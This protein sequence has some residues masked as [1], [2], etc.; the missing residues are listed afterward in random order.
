MFCCRMSSATWS[1]SGTYR[2]VRPWSGPSPNCCTLRWRRSS[3]PNYCPRPRTALLRSDKHSLYVYQDIS[4]RDRQIMK[5]V[6]LTVVL[7]FEF[8]KILNLEIDS[9]MKFISHSCQYH[10]YCFPW[11]HNASF[12]WPLVA[13]VCFDWS[14]FIKVFFWLVAVVEVCS[15]W[16]VGML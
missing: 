7:I 5:V 13:D 1:S 10:L 14:L 9:D 6:F 3:G 15:D 2:E 11:F 4:G 8:G 16:S 12:N